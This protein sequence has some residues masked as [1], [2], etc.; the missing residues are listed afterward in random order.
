VKLN[1][2]DFWQEKTAISYVLLPLTGLFIALTALRRLIYRLG[3]FNS[4]KS[5]LPVIVV[6]NITVGGSGKTPLVIWLVAHLKK[7]GYKPGIVSRGYGGKA[8]SWPQ[9]VRVDS[10]PETV[11]DEALL[12]ALRCHCPMAVAPKRA[13]AVRALEADGQVDIIISDDGLQHYAMGRD[14]EIAVVDGVRQQGNGFMLPAGPLREPVSRLD[15]VDLLITSQA[16]LRRQHHMEMMEPRI[17]PITDPQSRQP[18]SAW[19]GQQV[20]AIAGIGDPQRF[21]DML[22]SHGLSVIDMA[23]PDH[24][25]YQPSDLQFDDAIPLLMTE[26]DAVKCHPFAPAQTWVVSIDVEPDEP[27]K[28]RL[29]LLLNDV[30]AEKQTSEED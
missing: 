4:Y 6:G 25:S 15:S 28:H 18:L 30:A 9:Q 19:D 2:P 3:L 17:Y 1:Y 11:G 12:L 10:D 20:R 24:H 22:R 7:L 23:F 8:S 21:F 16:K 5:Q 29:S 14:I 27:F 13:D 26:K